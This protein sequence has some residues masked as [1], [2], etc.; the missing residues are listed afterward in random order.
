MLGSLNAYP[1]NAW[2]LN[3]YGGLVPITGASQIAQASQSLFASAAVSVVA[4]ST[5]SVAGMQTSSLGLV[6]VNGAASWTQE[7]S[8]TGVA[9]LPIAAALAQMQQDQ[10]LSSRFRA[11][12]RRH[13]DGSAIVGNA[14]GSA[15]IRHPAG[16][17]IVR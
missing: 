8:F 5:T 17:R 2:A 11:S 14:P 12:L 15:L 9:L 3:A 6:G 10:W 13:L 16:S 4:I 1:V 7:Q